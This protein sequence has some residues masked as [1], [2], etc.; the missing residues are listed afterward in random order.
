ML[1]IPFSFQ[2][3]EKYKMHGN[4]LIFYDY[5]YKHAIKMVHKNYVIDIKEEEKTVVPKIKTNRFRI[6]MQGL[7][8]AF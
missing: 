4:N 7:N 6:V 1:I 5:L 2:K 8:P 3:I